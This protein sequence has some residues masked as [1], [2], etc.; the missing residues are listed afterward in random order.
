MMVLSTLLTIFAYRGLDYKNGP[1]I[2]SIG[3]ILVMILSLIFFNEKV[4]KNKVIG[5]FLILLGILVFY[6]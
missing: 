3:Y 6:I 1:I 5:N 4:T 2:E